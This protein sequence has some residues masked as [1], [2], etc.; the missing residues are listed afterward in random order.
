MNPF[1]RH[2]SCVIALAFCLLCGLCEAQAYYGKG[3]FGRLEMLNDSTCTICF[4]IDPNIYNS[5]GG[6]LTD[7]CSLEKSG[8]T[9]YI[10]TRERFRFEAAENYSDDSLEKYPTV[11]KLYRNEYGDGYQLV[12][13]DVCYLFGKFIDI[14]D[15][16]GF[17]NGDLIVFRNYV[18]YDRFL[19]TYGKETHILI[20]NLV[21]GCCLDRFPLLMKGNKLIPIDKEKNEQCW[22]D[23][24]FYFPTMK[25]SNK[26]KSFDTIP[27]WSIGLNGVPNGH[28][29]YTNKYCKH[30]K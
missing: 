18:M 28:S 10:S 14:Y 8:D 6:K 2:L 7:T 19:W 21:D 27:R 1:N 23:N 15:F 25:K 3:N 22:I 12:Y 16:D 30:R 13:E 5:Q 20:D 29:L 4:I 24:G 11:F 9:I 26:T 17:R